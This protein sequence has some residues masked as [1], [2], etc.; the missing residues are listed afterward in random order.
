MRQAGW[1][2]REKEEELK[3]VTKKKYTCDQN[4]ERRQA[5]NWNSE[6]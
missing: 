1:M 6:S 2:S 3:T 5:G 4:Q